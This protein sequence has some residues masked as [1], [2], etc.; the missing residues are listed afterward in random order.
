MH[1]Y[2]LK[3]ISIRWSKKN[4][5]LILGLH[6]LDINTRPD[7]HLVISLKF[8]ITYPKISLTYKIVVRHNISVRDLVHIFMTF[9]S[10]ELFS[11]INIIIFCRPRCHSFYDRNKWCLVSETRERKLSFSTTYFPL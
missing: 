1:I 5:C 8:V 2:S 4:E 6:Y 7:N 9:T 3:K 11:F 10:G